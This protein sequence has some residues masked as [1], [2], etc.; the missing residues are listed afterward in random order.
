MKVW[1]PVD[2]EA[3]ID[4]PDL[5]LAPG[6]QDVF[7][8]LLARAGP[9]RTIVELRF[10]PDSRDNTSPDQREFRIRTISLKFG[11]RDK[12]TLQ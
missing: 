7:L 10:G 5:V 8:P 12:V 3:V 11:R 6:R 4:R 1:L 2:V 9:R